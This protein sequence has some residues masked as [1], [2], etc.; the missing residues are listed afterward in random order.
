MSTTSY[1]P[2]ERDN[3]TDAQWRADWARF[4]REEREAETRYRIHR[5]KTAIPR[6]FLKAAFWLVI[7]C[8][9]ISL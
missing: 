4:D 7:G 5:A 6:F 9:W 2:D 8:L 1:Q 3:W